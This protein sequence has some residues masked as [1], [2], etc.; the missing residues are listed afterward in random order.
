[1]CGTGEFRPY[2]DGE[3]RFRHGKKTYVVPSQ[4]YA[5]C[6]E[7]GTRGYIPGQRAR[8]SLSVAE[9]QSALIDYISPSEVLSV[10]ERYNLTQKQA[11]QL[12]KG[13]VN[14]FSKWERGTTFPSASTV[15]LLKLALSSNEV[16]QKLV[17]IAKV[18]FQVEDQLAV[19]KKITSDTASQ[20]NSYIQ[21][22]HAEYRDDAVDNDEIDTDQEWKNLNQPLIST[23]FT[24]LN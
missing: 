3:F 8:N 19:T 23:T 10:R 11:S 18:D 17:E 4:E 13:G 9:F 12:F 6:T 24:S 15:M 7:C 20:T 2:S 5:V 1:M 21:C 16:M 14:G 22:T